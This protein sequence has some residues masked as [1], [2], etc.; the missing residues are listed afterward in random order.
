MAKTINI[1]PASDISIEHSKYP[2]STA[3][4]YALI[5]DE[6]SDDDTSYITHNLTTSSANK[7]STFKCD[8]TELTGKIY[9]TGV[10]SLIR[11]RYELNNAEINSP[12]VR[13]FVSINN[14][15]SVNSSNITPTG[16]YVT[17]TYTYQTI[18][19]LN[20]IYNSINDANIVIGIYTSGS[21]TSGGGKTSSSASI[22]VTQANITIT[23]LDVFDCAAELI[24]GTGI[25]STSCSSSEVIDGNTCT[26]T[27]TLENNI[28]FIGWFS[29]EQGNNLVS[30]DRVYT[31]T[32]SENTTL[33]AKGSVLY[34]IDV[35]ADENCTVASS[36][37]SVLYGTAVTV[38]A[39]PNGSRYTFV[40]WYSN[41]ERT[42][43]ISEENPYTFNVHN[44]I[45]LYA[46]TKVNQVLYV[47]VNGVW[48]VFSK[49][50]KKI[51][52]EWVEQTDFSELFDANKNYVK[53]DI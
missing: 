11:S 42:N 43:L 1:Y 19:G 37:S 50:Y 6:T 12:T 21:Y 48:V 25:V 47:K 15:S 28:E 53:K 32:I 26:F 22:R 44:D 23:Y 45:V 41:P 35:Y 52:G 38:T 24:P 14:G 51:N 5:N 33:Y 18:S 34:D 29:D 30:T 27:A 31:T 39:T 40:G 16:S 20:T 9:L 4:A 8:N 49:A 2:T 7:T 13:T 17:N 46:K 3:N 10:S 36:A